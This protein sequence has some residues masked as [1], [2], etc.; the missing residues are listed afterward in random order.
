LTAKMAV[1]G[2]SRDSPQCLNIQ[3]HIAEDAPPAPFSFYACL[4]ARPDVQESPYVAAAPVRVVC[5]TRRS[6]VRLD[7][8]FAGPVV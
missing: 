6:N 1:G 2:S 7:P 3:L 4:A 5:L 8:I